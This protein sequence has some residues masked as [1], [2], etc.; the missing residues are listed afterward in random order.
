L[1]TAVCHC[2]DCQRQSASAF[3]IVVG[4][5][6]D[7]FRV[8]GDTLR[9]F[10]TIGEEHG[11]ENMRHFCGECGSPIYTANEHYPDVYILKAGTL[12]DTSWLEP[13]IELWGE[14]AQPW[15]EPTSA[16]PRL[17]RDPQRTA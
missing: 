4:V 10:T 6:R 12:D 8:D 1:F 11:S 5:S 3:S 17:P 15:V 9:S 7:A 16:R 2:R 14:S 13:Q